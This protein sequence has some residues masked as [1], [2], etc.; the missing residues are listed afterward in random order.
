MTANL[1]LWPRPLAI[2][3]NADVLDRLT[4][5]QQAALTDAAAPAV[6][7]S[8]DASR[9]EDAFVADALCNGPIQV[10]EASAD[11]LAAMRAAVQPVYDDLS[12]DSEVAAYLDEIEALKNELGAPPD[13]LT[14]LDVDENE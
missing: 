14:C 9:G 11:E 8:L 7:P 4:P 12:T 5:S 10:I 2:V 1:N 13:T 3:I 6:A